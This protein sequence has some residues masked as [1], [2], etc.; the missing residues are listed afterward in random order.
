MDEE[1]IDYD[2]MD[3]SEE[4]YQILIGGNTETIIKETSKPIIKAP[5]GRFF[6]D[7]YVVPD[8]NRDDYIS[9]LNDEFTANRYANCSPLDSSEF[10]HSDR[11]LS[12]DFYYEDFKRVI[13]IFKAYYGAGNLVV[14]N[15][16]RSPHEIG[17]GPH[18]TGIAIDIH[19]EDKIQAKKVM[20]AA[21][22]AGISTII[23]NG[24]YHLGEGYVHL[25]IAPRADYAYDGGTYK[26]P[27][28]K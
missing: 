9:Y 26:G 19:V 24:E 16:F 2:E 22:M 7:N 15:G 4:D 21:F 13:R 12:I 17:V 1:M 6:R 25:D 10:M 8:Y 23:P 11:S 27:W 14:I 3:M 28:S 5:R 20:D 18:S